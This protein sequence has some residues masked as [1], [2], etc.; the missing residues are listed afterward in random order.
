MVNKR[1]CCGC[2]ACMNICPVGAIQMISDEE[3]FLYPEINKLKCINCN[4][5]VQVCT[6]KNGCIKRKQPVEIWAVQHKDKNVRIVSSSGGVFT[7]M[8]RSIIEHDGIVY[9]ARFDSNFMVE[10]ARATTERECEAFRGA[11]YVQSNMCPGGILKKVELDLKQGKIVLFSGTPCQVAGLKSYLKDDS[12]NNLI[13]CDIICHGVPSPVIWKQY[14]DLI[15]KKSQIK[16]IHFRNK[17]NGWH[18]SRLYI[19]KMD[20]TFIAQSHAENPYSNLYFSHY[21]LRESCTVC[22]YASFERVGDITIGDFWGIENSIPD[23]DD[24]LG[25]SIVMVNSDKGKKLL[26]DIWDTLNVRATD[27]EHCMQPNLIM[28]SGL[29]LSREKFWMRYHNKGLK[30]VMKYYTAYGDQF[31]S[32]RIRRHLIKL[33]RV[34]VDTICKTRRMRNDFDK[35]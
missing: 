22:P 10:H 4:A 17:E 5:C 32:V 21:I 26:E 6:F 20:G 11:K 24:D 23:L 7:S 35:R 13:T 30:T 3:G 27:R 16:N 29:P 34:L 28:P 8:Y 31:I 19:N 18:N 12:P 25:T 14:L 9:G 33:K 15:K 2:T 1:E